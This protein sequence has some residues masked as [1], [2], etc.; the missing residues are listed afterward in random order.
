MDKKAFRLLFIMGCMMAPLHAEYSTLGDMA[1]AFIN[2][3][4]NIGELLIGLGYLSGV[5]FGIASVYKFK[6][7]KDNPTQIPIGTP[8]A[9]LMVSILM[10]SM[11]G[12]IGVV[13]TTIFGDEPDASM[14]CQGLPGGD[15]CP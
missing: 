1:D 14:R 2:M 12:L 6:Q 10:V 5:G 7:Y 9:L 13:T 11:P 15:G 3:H 8:F 4:L